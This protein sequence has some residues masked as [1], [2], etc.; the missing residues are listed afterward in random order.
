MHS[1]TCRL[2]QPKLVI[3][4]NACEC[5]ILRALFKSPDSKLSFSTRISQLVSMSPL[6]FRGLSMDSPWAIFFKFILIFLLMSH[7]RIILPAFSKIV[8][9]RSWH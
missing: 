1:S 4:F 7:A 9:G 3:W 8:N 5:M 2:V 6:L